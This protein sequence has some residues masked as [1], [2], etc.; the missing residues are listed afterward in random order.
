MSGE[1]AVKIKDVIVEAWF[2]KQPVATDLHQW[3]NQYV[4]HWNDLI[5]K[6]PVANTPETLLNF[7]NTYISKGKFTV[8]NPPQELT[9]ATVKQYFDN[10]LNKYSAYEKTAT[11]VPSTSLTPASTMPK[12]PTGVQVPMGQRLVVIPKN[13]IQPIE[14]RRHGFYKMNDGW[15]DAGG[16]PIDDKNTIAKLEKLAPNGKLEPLPSKFND[17]AAD[18]EKHVSG[19]NE[20]IK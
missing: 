1:F 12:K 7:V 13:S 10:V 5:S 2:K 3:T 9:P 15:Y 17:P 14:Q 20:S 4:N 11:E 18:W 6:N 8:D 16:N 19:A